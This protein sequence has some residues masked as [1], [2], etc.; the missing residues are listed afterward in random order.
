MIESDRVALE[1]LIGKQVMEMRVKEVDIF[2]KNFQVLGTNSTFL[3]GL[4]FSCVYSKPT[5]M[6]TVATGDRLAGWRDFGSWQEVALGFAAA[7][8][9]GLNIIVMGVSAYVLIFGTDLALRGWDGSMSRALEGMY[10][11]RAALLQLYFV[12][13]AATIVVAASLALAKLRSEISVVVLSVLFIGGVMV[14][15]FIYKHTRELF[16]FPDDSSEKP[17]EMKLGGR[18]DPENGNHEDRA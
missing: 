6:D 10:R 4:T 17:T 11:E 16:R 13:V 18:Y 8:A 12:G 2:V 1:A 7:F 14:F 15:S 3:C 5:F 9:V